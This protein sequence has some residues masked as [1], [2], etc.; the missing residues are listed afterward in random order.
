MQET[1]PNFTHVQKADPKSVGIRFLHKLLS[2]LFKYLAII[3]LHCSNENIESN[4]LRNTRAETQSYQTCPISD[5]MSVFNPACLILFL[6]N[7][8]FKIV[9][10]HASVNNNSC[11]LIIEWKSKILL[12]T[13]FIFLTVEFKPKRKLKSVNIIREN[14]KCRKTY[15][16]NYIQSNFNLIAGVCKWQNS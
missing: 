15:I 14:E 4:C 11:T 12:L 7:R 3:Y 5:I 9:R 1:D 6:I 10:F 16:S 2:C 13:W 8:T